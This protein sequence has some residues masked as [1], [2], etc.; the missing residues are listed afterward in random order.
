MQHNYI[1]DTELL[2]TL[3]LP[4]IRYSTGSNHQLPHGNCPV[5]LVRVH[6]HVEHPHPLPHTGVPATVQGVSADRI[7]LEDY[8]CTW[9][10]APQGIPSEQELHTKRADKQ[11]DLPCEDCCS[12]Y[13]WP[14]R[15]LH[16]DHLTSVQDTTHPC[17][18]SYHTS[19]V[20][21]ILLITLFNSSTHYGDNNTVCGE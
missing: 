14:G 20:S 7:W 17:Q 5:P 11:P 12:E 2:Y 10:K 8:L 1:L 15:I 19:T 16:S 6:H 18:L 4:F 3:I 21:D 9:K 13:P